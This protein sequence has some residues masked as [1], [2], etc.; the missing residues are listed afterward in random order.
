MPGQTGERGSHALVIGGSLTGLVTAR[1]LCDYFDRVT[2]VERDEYPDGP[3]SR[4]GIPQSRHIHLLL[5][6]GQLILE[7][8]FP[9]LRDEMIAA[10]AHVVDMGAD[11]AWWTHAG[12]GIRFPSDLSMLTQTRG[13]LDWHL[14][15]RARELEKLSFMCPFGVV[16]LLPNAGGDGVGGVVVRSYASQ[17]EGGGEQQEVRADL[18]VDATGRGSRAPQWLKELGYPEVETTVVNARIGYATRLYRRPA[19]WDEWRSLFVEASPPQRT[20]AAGLVPVEGDRWIVTLC[21]RLGDYPPTDEEG[22][23]EFARS[24][25]SRA[26]YD[27]IKDAESASPIYGCRATEN[28]VRHFERLPRMPENFVAVGD[29][30]CTLN[31]VY[32]QGMTVAALGALTF[33]ETLAEHRSRHPDGSLKGLSR[34]F[35]RRV[36]KV[37]DSAWLLAT[38]EDFRYPETKNYPETTCSPT[39]KMRLMH[40]Y[41]NHVGRL[42]VIDPVV[43]TA[44]LKT[45]HMLEK[46][47]TLF[48]PPI[49]LR[50][51]KHALRK[52]AA[53]RKASPAG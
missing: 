4:K 14:R 25:A 27:A 17:D 20:R 43:R 3:S 32:G 44:E 16:R 46:P 24:L 48:R 36:A 37:N 39:L 47:N 22:F 30:I 7:Q 45:F 26:L 41:M 5:K 2:V 50:V 18:V 35:Q 42:S 8:F 15:R 13:L 28:R 33:G 51:I 23:L 38:G 11:L 53:E 34:S 19:G 10:G 9:G 6:R 29:A 12:W 1:I 21:G 52:G 40:R 31:P 49:L